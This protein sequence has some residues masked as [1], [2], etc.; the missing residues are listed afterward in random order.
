MS[1]Y[2]RQYE[3]EKDL[4]GPPY[5]EFEE[6]LK[7]HAHPDGRALDLGCGQGRD[8]LLLARYGYTVTGVDSSKVGVA[9][10][11][12][13]AGQDDLHVEGVVADIYEYEPDGTFDAVVLDSI[14]HFTGKDRVK[15]LALLDR[16]A[17]WVNGDGFLFIFVHKSRAREKILNTWM[18]GI[19]PSF[20]Q[21]AKGYIDYRY[22]EKTSGF[23]TA[24]QYYMLLIRRD[25]VRR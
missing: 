14:L 10:M 4:F 21:I 1:R 9:Q 24:F 7:T 2:D 23:K 8:A 11:L 15:E 13:R 16:V 6:F 17:S 19:K 20:K 25:Q 18:E 5:R 3:L 22:E 12:E